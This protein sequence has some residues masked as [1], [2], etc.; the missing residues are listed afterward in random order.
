MDLHTNIYKQQIGGMIF[1]HVSAY[2][3]APEK[4]NA[5]VLFEFGSPNQGQKESNIC[6]I[7]MLW[8]SVGTTWIKKFSPIPF[9]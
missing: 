6:E 8:N 1:F 2:R 3:W 7:A 4:K 5:A 9:K